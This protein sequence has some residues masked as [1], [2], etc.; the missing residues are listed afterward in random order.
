MQVDPGP[1]PQSTDRSTIIKSIQL[2]NKQAAS[3]ISGLEET[4]SL[5]QGPLGTCFGFITPEQGLASG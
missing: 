1:T 2:D 4:I 5:I 3:L